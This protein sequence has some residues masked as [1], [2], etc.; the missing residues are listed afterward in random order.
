MLRNPGFQLSA[1]L[2]VLGIFFKT[3]GFFQTEPRAE[4]Y[5]LG[6]CLEEIERNRERQLEIERECGRQKERVR[7]IE[8]EREKDILDRQRDRE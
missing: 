3:F 2:Y 1:S 7:E 8:K 5:W 6:L 4:L